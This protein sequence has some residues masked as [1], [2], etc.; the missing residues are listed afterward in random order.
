MPGT[1]MIRKWLRSCL[2]PR[3]RET[4]CRQ[5]RL[6]VGWDSLK[7]SFHSLTTLLLPRF[8][9]VRPGICPVVFLNRLG[10]WSCHRDLRQKV[11]RKSTLFVSIILVSKEYSI[12]HYKRLPG[13]VIEWVQPATAIYGHRCD[14]DSDYITRSASLVL[15]QTQKFAGGNWLFGFER[16][17]FIRLP[18]QIE[19]FCGFK[20]LTLDWGFKIPEDMTKQ[21]CF[22]FG[23]IHLCVNGK[24][25]PL[26]RRSGFVTNPEQFPLV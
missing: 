9:V 2:L 19:K 7:F 5:K 10:C 4:K 1:F 18:L 22:Y 26:L 12:T 21:E 15:P 13:P 16:K 24:T 14:Y 11:W 8:R 17:S 25:N 20:V 3:Q 6:G 23:F